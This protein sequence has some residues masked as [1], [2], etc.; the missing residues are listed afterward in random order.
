MPGVDKSPVRSLLTSICL[1]RSKNAIDLPS[2]MDKIHRVDFEAEEAMHYKSMNDSLTNFF[3]KDTEH[4]QIVNYSNILTKINSL[5][6]IC[7]LGTYYQAQL[8]ARLVPGMHGSIM[9]DLFDGM[10]STGVARC[11]KC[12][13]DFSAGEGSN[14]TISGGVDALEFFQPQIAACGTILCASCFSFS[15][16]TSRLDQRGCQHQPSCEL[17]AVAVSHFS[18]GPVPAP[19]TR[20]PVKMRALQRDVVE[21]PHADKRYVSVLCLQTTTHN[22][23]SIIFSFWTTTLDVVET[24]LDEIQMSYTRVDG[25]MPSKQRQQ[26]LDSFIEDPRIRAILISL[27]CGANG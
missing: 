3:Q 8:H 5:R 4:K 24:A 7:N 23:Y 11:S 10:L 2:R 16:I 13:M 17:F 1:R 22:C 19:I 12:D 9:Q 26:A 21:L 27:R 15:H 18:I 14:E 25:T 20:L 6:Q